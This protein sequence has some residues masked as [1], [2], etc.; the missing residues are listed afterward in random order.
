ME[1]N[2]CYDLIGWNSSLREV[3]KFLGLVRAKI[4]LNKAAWNL[5]LEAYRSGK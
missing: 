3:L 5:K 1:K 2:F 4:Q